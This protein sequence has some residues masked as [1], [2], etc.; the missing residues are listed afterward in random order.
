MLTAEFN[1]EPSGYAE[2]KQL[3]LQRTLIDRARAMPGVD[4]A[5]LAALVPLDF[6]R[7]QVGD[8]QLPGT[9]R[10]LSPFVNLVSPGFFQTLDIHLQGRDFDTHD[11]KG[12]TEVCVVNA[13]LAHRLAPDGDVIGR[14]YAFGSTKDHHTLT[15]I[16]V[17]PDGKYASL[18]EDSEPFLF[19]PLAQWPRA[20][21]SLLVK[22]ALPANT[23]AAQLHEVMHAVDA[24]LPSA[25]VQSLADILA[26]SLLPQR[27]AAMTSLALGTIGL[28]LAAVG[29][30]GLIA[31]YVAAR[32]REFGVRLALGASPRRILTE[33]V[34]RGALLSGIG[35]ALGTLLA[36]GGAALVS[37]LLYGARRQMHSHSSLPPCC[38]RPSRCWP[39]IC[40]RDT[41]H[42]SL[43]SRRCAM[44]KPILLRCVS[45]AHRAPNNNTAALHDVIGST[46]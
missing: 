24:S 32:T 37:G 29:L 16:G 34:R 33:V 35:L 28:L 18:S 23:F 13:T 26:L 42:A 12:A 22:S 41:R 2:A 40:P 9:S 11:V 46:Q 38:S 10:E 30:Y 14:S 45:N 1:L 31:M 8:F 25:R 36:L 19:L 20:E 6:S 3:E 7:M 15:V 4:R 27:I 43:R 44:N 17:T 39:A 5:A 21:T